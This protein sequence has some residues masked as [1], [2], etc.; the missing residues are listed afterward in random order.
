LIFCSKL[1]DTDLCL[2]LEF[3]ALQAIESRHHAP[4]LIVTSLQLC[5]WSHG[6]EQP[7]AVCS[8]SSVINYI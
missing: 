6:M 8:N 4:A 5:H 3:F 1:F 2:L 7:A